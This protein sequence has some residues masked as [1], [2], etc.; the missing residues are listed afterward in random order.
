MLELALRHFSGVVYVDRDIS[1]ASKLLRGVYEGPFP[2]D[3]KAV[4]ASAI[5][6][7]FLDCRDPDSPHEPLSIRH[8]RGAIRFAGEICRLNLFSCTS[9]LVADA[10]FGRLAALAERSAVVDLKVVQEM[11][12]AFKEETGYRAYKSNICSRCKIE[13]PKDALHE[14]AVPCSKIHKPI[15]CGI[16]CQKADWADHRR[17]CKNDIVI[18]R[19]PIDD[20][21]LYSVHLA[22]DTHTR[23]FS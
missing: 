23:T 2:Q 1:A 6:Y 17:W 3:K 19:N 22:Q 10:A 15:Y 18:I 12:L 5:A 21:A 8:R 20:P 9:V 13:Q 16:A 14:C 7:L 4:A 11:S